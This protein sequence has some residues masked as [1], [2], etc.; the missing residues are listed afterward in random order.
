MRDLHVII[1]TGPVGRATAEALAARG[2]KIRIISKTGRMPDPPVGAEVRGMNIL[3]KEALD[4]A[5]MD[6]A[7]VYQCAQPPYGRWAAEFP[8]FQ[9]AVL[10]A[11]ERA[12][13]RLLLAE[14]LY[15]YG[16]RGGAPIRDD[17]GRGRPGLA[18]AER[19][20]APNPAG[21]SVPGGRAFWP[22]PAGQGPG[23]PGPH[24]GFPLRTR[25]SGTPAPALPVRKTLRRGVRLLP[26]PLRDGTDSL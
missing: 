14:N 2:R 12:G 22:S 11:A 13:A 16:D 1:G 8:A 3:D 26:E 4:A 6:A 19:P 18:C 5:V 15:G 21:S 7:G 25:G 9:R 23:T 10:E 24:P 20:A 17:G